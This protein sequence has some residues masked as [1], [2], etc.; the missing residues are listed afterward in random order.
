VINPEGRERDRGFFLRSFRFVPAVTIVAID[1][2]VDF[3]LVEINGGREFPVLLS[4]SYL[5][6]S[7]TMPTQTKGEQLIEEIKGR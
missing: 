4:E 6:S 3:A 2:Q 5:Y 7:Q 1:A